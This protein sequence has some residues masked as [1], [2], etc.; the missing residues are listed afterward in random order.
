M[1]L[2]SAPF[3]DIHLEFEDVFHGRQDRIA[4]CLRWIGEA[5]YRWHRRALLAALRFDGRR[6]GV[7]P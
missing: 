7:W 2:R 1:K 6:H 3:D 5:F 4:R